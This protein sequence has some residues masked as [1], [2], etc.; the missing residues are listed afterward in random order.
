[1][2]SR[3]LALFVAAAG[4]LSGGRP[5]LR[6]LRTTPDATASPAATITIVF[7]RP[8]A[9]SL[10]YTIDPRT[11][12]H[13]EPEIPGTLEWRDPITIRLTPAH[14]LTPG[15][16]YTVVVSPSFHAMDGSQLAEP[17]R[18][19]FKTLGPTPLWG[20]PANPDSD[21]RF[22]EPTS[23]FELA[24]SSPPD[25]ALLETAH[26]VFD[27]RCGGSVPLDVTG[28][29]RPLNDKDPWRYHQPRPDMPDSLRRVV[30]LTPRSRLPV[31]CRGQLV[32]GTVSWVFRTYGAFRLDT[33]G[34]DFNEGC[35]TGPIEVR[36]STP[37]RGTEVRR[38]V[39]IFPA[40][41]F[42]MS[43][44][45][46]E[47]T[48]WQLDARL[49]PRSTY[50]VVADTA[51]RDV[52]GQRLTGNPATGLRTP[53]FEP[54][55]EYPFGRLLVER[56]GFRTLAIQHLNVD[57]LVAYVVPVS[58]SLRSELLVASPWNVGGLWRRV[59]K[60]AIERRI[61]VTNVRDKGFVTLLRLPGGDTTL[62][63]V[64]VVGISIHEP[65]RFSR[66]SLLESAPVA[67]LEISDLGVHAKIGAD[68][69]A[70]WVT[71]A[72]DGQPRAGV[73][74][75][76]HNA[77]GSPVASATTDADGVAHL[78]GYTPNKHEEEEE[79]E[80]DNDNAEGPTTFTGFVDAR[81]GDDRAVLGVGG[82][83]PDLSPWQ[84]NVQPAFGTSSL[85]G[86][87][88]VF[89]DR[90][91]YRPGE[92]IHAKAIVR[93][94]L[95]GSLRVPP[96]GDSLR[97]ELHDREFALIKDTT[98]HLSAFGT[99]DMTFAIPSNAGLGTYSVRARVHTLGTWRTLG[100][101]SV[102]IAEYRP[103]EFLVD[104]ST[105]SAPT[106]AGDSMRLVAQA[107][108]LFGAPMARAAVQWQAVQTDLWPWD[109]Q[110]PGT[111]GWEIG[112]GR[113]WE[114]DGQAA[115]SGEPQSVFA[116]GTDTLDGAGRLAWRVGSPRPSKGRGARV[117][118]QATVTDVNRQNVVASASTIVH[119]AAFYIAAKVHG[120]VYFWTAG[121]PVAIDI[122]AVRPT[123]DRV[124][125]VAVRGVV[126]RREWHQVRRVR[127]GVS[128]LVGD[129]VIDTVG[130]CDVTTRTDPVSCPVTPRN[131]GE[132]AVTW[133]ASD[134]SGRPVLTSL[135]RWVTGP[136]WVP[137]DDESQF[138]MNVVADRAS[139][140][141]GDTATMLVAS[142]IT[143]VEAWVTVEREGI[144]EQRRIHIKDGSTTLKIP[145]T[146]AFVPN[147]F[148]SVFA[149]RGRSAPP[150]KL[151]DPGRPTIRVGYA[152]VRVLPAVKTLAVSLDPDKTEYR[153]GD[154]ARIAIQVRGPRSEVT[155]WAVD[156]G[157]LA[158]T[159][160]KTP[161]PVGLLYAERGLG[162]RLS[163]NLSSVAPQVP[164]GE[165]GRRAP[166][167][168]G[169]AAGGDVLRSR[170]Q[171]TAFFLSSVVTDSTGHA[172]A[173]AKLPDNLT[174]FRVMA[175]AV[176]SGDRYGSAQTPLLVTRPLLIRPALPRFVRAGDTFTAG[177]V[178]NQRAGGSA[179]VRV[180]AEVRGADRHGSA[181]QE[182][183]VAPGR[184]V[185]V[186]FPF[187]V[188]RQPG[189]S[190]TFTLGVRPRE[191][192]ADADRV[193][194][195][196][197]VRPDYT[198]RAHTIAGALRDT[199][200]IVLQL[201]EGTDPAR[202]KVSISAGASVLAMISGAAKS[203][204]VYPYACSEQVTSEALPLLALLRAAPAD[205][206]DTADVKRQLRLA[207]DILSRRQRADGGIGLW[208]ANDWTSPYLSAYAGE[209][210]VG[211]RVAG[212]AVDDS[213]LTRLG[214]Y[215]LGVASTGKAPMSPVTEIY[216]EAG[217]PLSERVSAVAFL[218]RVG[219]PDIAAEDDLVRQAAQLWPIDRARLAAVVAGRSD[220]VSIAR[221]LLE[222]E[223]AMARIEGRRAI[224]PD[225]AMHAWYFPRATWMTAEVLLA[226][227][228]VDPSHPLIG[229]LVETLVQ[230]SRAGQY[231]WL[232]TTHDLA[233]LVTALSAYDAA[234]RAAVAR[235]MTIRSAGRVVDSVSSLAGLL[236]HGK[237]KLSLTANGGANDTPVYYY[238]T[239]NEVPLRRNVTP[240]DQGIT[241]ERWYEKYDSKAP[242]VSVAEGDLVRVQL[243]ITVRED[244]Q[245]VVLDDPLPAGLE[246]VDLSLATSGLPGP[247]VKEWE[248]ST[249]TW[250]YGYW[251][252]G[253]W[254]PFDHREMR[255]DRVVYVATELWAGKYTVS[256]VAR[257]TTP[258][259]FIRPPATATE[260]YN[261]AVQGRSDGGVFT[262]TQ[263]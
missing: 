153:P 228:A 85:P 36:F 238:M 40:T 68:R 263:K 262:V 64:K 188:A 123:G 252:G 206:I 113:W 247:G 100:F 215:M 221:A 45:A 6:I 59:S 172:V 226:T 57:T 55:V 184:G 250:G 143:N 25:Q 52:F 132:Y 93:R 157:V 115:E 32:V 10:D 151:D 148:V 253:W 2:H 46:L 28:S 237:L 78:N 176:T 222:P 187:A 214:R 117:H 152:S 72:T 96:T 180:H 82:Y 17:Y 80:D 223:W 243:R 83:E 95:L 178:V 108:Y 133:T 120:S 205:L 164:E 114:D 240:D 33:V 227:L 89:T 142:P 11:I 244:R 91:I 242:V 220:G 31:G 8:V 74:V 255:D 230:Q 191:A 24:W 98:V 125:G 236:D 167:G 116:S 92:S 225:S 49:V 201:P 156:E 196:V 248:Q 34:C 124:A 53:G 259:I 193:R 56:T 66:R 29:A 200:T 129:W 47:A 217:A 41:P 173:V 211:A 4:L 171:T 261:P 159:A 48:R 239:V 158:L 51:L 94:G 182:A 251:D 260:M 128:D 134:A 86:A 256:Y 110:I 146:E 22:V 160:Y 254:S 194:L 141:V 150:G 109:L 13:V 219:R 216:H 139:Y 23:A 69:G 81:L 246:A 84:F 224:F 234:E 7:D 165:K 111:D 63:A 138:K 121:T 231:E 162:V 119:P 70:V 1:M 62:V 181:E 168:G 186:R 61:P 209:L 203:L 208:D 144:I 102:R 235:G 166:G 76:L 174:T 26:L 118:V 99:T 177:G 198:P 103:P 18:F 38:H 73:R 43:D 112:D 5:P 135:A 35:P 54:A 192:R 126:T 12:V 122:I 137:W 101:A 30:T 42:T 50:A 19:S 127:N 87:V 233:A 3:Q 197:P 213:V 77:S 169:G 183:L 218:R 202:S 249:E 245:F 229:P 212:L 163:S 189:D 58:D 258:G 210:L 75:T 20:T 257:A 190:V 9:G 131:G 27:P 21:G 195:S 106:F 241:V 207:V 39:T 130:T 88:A 185:E 170:F 140:K 179:A 175:V 16:T 147:A 105:D 90:G 204:Y 104:V 136:G 65:T 161:D 44:T 107:R 71:G 232:W 97:W 60:R 14:P 155:L 199:A 149:T 37:V 145:I 154:S 67:V 15:A 79:E